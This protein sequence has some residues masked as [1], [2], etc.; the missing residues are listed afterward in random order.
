MRRLLPFLTVGLSL[1]LFGRVSEAQGFIGY[2]ALA[3]QNGNQLGNWTVSGNLSIDTSAAPDRLTL[4]AENGQSGS[5]V[6]MAPAP[7][8]YDFNYSASITG[9]ASINVIWR[10]QQATI[11]PGEGSS[12]SDIISGQPYGFELQTGPNS[13][14]IFEINNFTT[15]PEPLTTILLLLGSLFLL[16]RLEPAS[17]ITG[18]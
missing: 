3:P 10:S 14:A 11:T 7:S 13:S 9:D 18:R 12:F 17:S 16:R 4:R 8:Q 2:F 6:I 5:L 1:T 15:V